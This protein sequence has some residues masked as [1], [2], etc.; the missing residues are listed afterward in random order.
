M[1]LIGIIEAGQTVFRIAEGTRMNQLENCMEEMEFG[2]NQTQEAV[3]QSK[4]EI[5]TIREEL[6]KDMEAS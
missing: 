2:V 4:E 5:K 6:R 1:L 3:A